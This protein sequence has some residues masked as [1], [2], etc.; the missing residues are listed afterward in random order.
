M[1]YPARYTPTNDEITEGCRRIRAGWGEAEARRR[2]SPN[3][4]P[5]PVDVKVVHVSSQLRGELPQ[6][7][8]A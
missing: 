2:T 8:F 6:D 4:L 5:Q 7:E 3:D 1:A